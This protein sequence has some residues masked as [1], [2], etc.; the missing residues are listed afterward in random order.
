MMSGPLP[1]DEFKEIF[2][3]VPRTTVEVV[4]VSPAG[5]LLV[6]RLDGPCEGLWTIPG[7]TVRYGEPLLDAVARVALS[8]LGVP[9]AV[10]QML[11]Y[12]EY[13]SHLAQGIDW[14]I[15]IAFACRLASPSGDLESSTVGP[16]RWFKVLPREMHEE[17]RSFLLSAQLGD[18]ALS[19][20]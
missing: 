6:E 8:E 4:V 14:P 3:K 17:Q 19:S 16:G 5:V 12:L 7:G 20:S 11:G 1:E 2:S 18:V 9:I 13:P 15:G 10:G